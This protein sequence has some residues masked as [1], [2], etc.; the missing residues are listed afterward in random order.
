VLGSNQRRL[1]RRFY[2]PIL[3]FES[4][5]DDLRLC[6]SRLDLGPPPSAMR[7]W[8]PGFGVRAVDRPSQAGLRTAT[9]QPTDGG[10]KGHG[11]GRWERL[12][13]PSAWLLASDLAFF[14]FQ[15]AADVRA[16]TL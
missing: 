12:R 8:A 10:G 13:R 16:A 2:S 3:L 9:D 15:L 1:S 5:A 6:A 11:R 4:Y 7:P 14:G